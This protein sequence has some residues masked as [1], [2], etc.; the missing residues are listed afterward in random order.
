MVKGLPIFNK[1]FRVVAREFTVLL[2]CFKAV[3][4]VFVRGGGVVCFVC[5]FTFGNMFGVVDEVLLGNS[6]WC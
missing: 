1:M 5:F 2:V 6:G 4:K 3:A